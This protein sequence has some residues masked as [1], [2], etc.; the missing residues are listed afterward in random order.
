MRL[1][2]TGSR[3]MFTSAAALVA[4]FWVSGATTGAQQAA[5]DGKAAPP[6][7]K[8]SIAGTVV[9]AGTN[10]AV[11]AA[12]V[13]LSSAAL[14]FG[15]SV[16][17]D[18]QGAFSFPGLAAG[19]YTLSVMKGGFVE[20]IYGQRQPGS[21]RPGT[22]IRVADGQQISRLSMT[23]SRGG[24]IT[25]ALVDETGEPAFGVPVRAYRWVMQAGQRTAQPAAT[26]LTDDRGAYRL[27][28]L[29]PGE[30]LIH[31]SPSVA[32]VM[33]L[34]NEGVNYSKVIGALDVA[35]VDGL[36]VRM[37]DA[38]GPLVA[39]TSGFARV[40]YPGTT[41]WSAAETVTI[42]AGEERSGIDIPMHIVPLARISGLVISPT[43]PVSG[44]SLQ[45][46]ER[47]GPAFSI[48]R[49]ARTDKEGRFA[50]DG[51]SPG[52]VTLATKS[53]AKGAPQLEA[54]AREAAE[55]L[56][57]STDPAKVQSIAAAISRVATLW[58]TAEVSVDGRNQ[59]DLQLFLQPGLTVS[60]QVTIADGEAPVDLSRVTLGLTS[61]GALGD[62]AQTTPA[63]VE[64]NGR[65]TIR[66]VIPGKYRLTAMAGLPAGYS[67]ASAVFGGQDT[68]DSP[69]EIDGSRS[70]SGG[71]VTLSSRTTEV[72]GV[73]RDTANQPATGFTVIVFATDD[74]FWT[75]ASRRIQAVRASTDGRYAF[76][77]LPA[78]DYRVIAVPDVEPG[79][80][81]DPVFLGQ[82]AGFTTFTL[83][84][85]ARHVQ[86][87]QV[88]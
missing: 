82:L 32:S 43:G 75:P 27:H 30:Y 9:T 33:L 67:L 87:F 70:V 19:E 61:V 2:P 15:R 76:K 52:Q 24:V 47:L 57:S 20:S 69:L 28:S 41:V 65:F 4:I 63:P 80:W 74:R 13:T 71:S 46:S 68:L 42:G 78:G 12:S 6:A 25:G 16:Q 7:G 3:L 11:R 40:F 50:F 26:A 34:P 5:R 18:D 59:T 54:S 60:G 86:D 88:R 10:R 53:T 81:F 37:A 64:P 56:A 22:P 73:L 85:G 29:L 58:A 48:V 14:R 36:R 23:L 45:L 77:N 55:F 84:A 44:A 38:E 83:G 35:M 17:T 49:T 66:G 31:A 21:G 62:F 8:A 39:A 79:R 72:S 1:Y 51:V